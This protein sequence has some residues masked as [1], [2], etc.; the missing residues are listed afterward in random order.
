[1]NRTTRKARIGKTVKHNA[2]VGNLHRRRVAKVR[3][4]KERA[5]IVALEREI[6][7]SV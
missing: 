6:A 1:M 2:R 3:W 5:E 7:G 4:L